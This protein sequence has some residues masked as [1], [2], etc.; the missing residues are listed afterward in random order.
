MF[1]FKKKRKNQEL[2][3]QP[4]LVPF[5][6]LLADCQHNLHFVIFALSD[7]HNLCS[8]SQCSMCPFVHVTMT[9]TLYLHNWCTVGHI[10]SLFVFQL[11]LLLFCFV[12]INL[13]MLYLNM[14]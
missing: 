2:T 6:S 3:P 5:N 1:E 7:V 9:T 12:L 11:C 4:E 14:I 8:G 10:L 13:F